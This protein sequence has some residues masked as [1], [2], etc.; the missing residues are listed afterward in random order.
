[1]AAQWQPSAPPPP[2]LRAPRPPPEKRITRN[3]SR[4][5]IANLT[6]TLKPPLVTRDGERPNLQNAE[7]WQDQVFS[8]TS[9]AQPILHGQRNTAVMAGQD[10]GAGLV[11]G[12]WM[13][14]LPMSHSEG[15]RGRSTLDPSLYNEGSRGCSP[16][17]PSL[18]DIGS[19]RI[20]LPSTKPALPSSTALTA[21][22]LCPCRIIWA[23]LVFETT[24]SRQSCAFCGLVRPPSLV[25]LRPF[26]TGPNWLDYVNERA[27]KGQSKVSIRE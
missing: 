3:I 8:K 14:R 24:R 15:S 9:P 22:F 20:H 6:E 5:N 25:T 4:A 13:H 26:V 10:G 27:M 7:D 17:D 23:G 21:L 16:L 19:L 1:M 18:L 2:S 12:T 11:E